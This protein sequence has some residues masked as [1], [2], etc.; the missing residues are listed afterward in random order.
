VAAHLQLFA[1]DTRTMAW[2]RPTVGGE[3]PAG[4][5]WHTAVVKGALVFVFGGVTGR[6]ECVDDKCDVLS[7]V[8]VLDTERMMWCKVVVRGSH[9][10][11]VPRRA[12]V[13]S[14]VT[15]RVAASPC[16]S[17][18]KGVSPPGRYGHSAVLYEAKMCIFGG[19]DTPV[20]SVVP[21]L[22]DVAFFDTETSM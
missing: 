17:Q 9:C 2:S 13:R 7:D 6:N 8:H 19:R 10:G 5:A 11:G 20:S 22:H 3:Y 16:R 21:P 1:L 12:A 4:R 14:C 18:V 15:S